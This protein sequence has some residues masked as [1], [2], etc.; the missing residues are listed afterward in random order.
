MYRNFL[1]RTQEKQT[2]MLTAYY[3]EKSSSLTLKMWYST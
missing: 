1:G 3:A 2:S